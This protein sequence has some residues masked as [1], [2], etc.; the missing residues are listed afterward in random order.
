VLCGS[1]AASLI[2]SSFFSSSVCS[3]VG[4]KFPGAD[5][6]AGGWMQ[7]VNA[8]ARFVYCYLEPARTAW[9]IIS[10]LRE[11]LVLPLHHTPPMP[12]WL[13]FSSLGPTQKGSSL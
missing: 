11:G 9:D 12:H 10:R 1:R 13:S 5:F 6:I 4:A 7:R 3:L 8:H 2:F